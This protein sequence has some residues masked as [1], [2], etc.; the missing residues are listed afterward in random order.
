MEVRL[1][2]DASHGQQS[3]R[4]PTPMK[5][6]TTTLEASSSLPGVAKCSCCNWV[7][8]IAARR[9]AEGE[10][11][12]PILPRATIYSRAPPRDYKCCAGVW[13]KMHASSIHTSLLETEK[14]KFGQ[15]PPFAP[16]DWLVQLRD[17]PGFRMF[18]GLP[19]VCRP[20][21]PVRVPPR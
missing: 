15:C 11:T 13:G 10:R 16:S 2:G 18:S 17:W 4:S 7:A 6:D 21:N 9:L 12:K 1:S 5:T 8:L 3:R 20:W 19:S 14:K